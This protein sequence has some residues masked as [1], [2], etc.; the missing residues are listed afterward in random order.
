MRITPPVTTPEACEPSAAEVAAIRRNRLQR[1]RDE[2]ARADIAACVLFDP[3]HIRYATGSRNMQIYSSRNPARYLFV[4]AGG[5][6]V[7]FE[8]SGCDHL[9]AHLDTIDEVRPATAISYYFCGDRLAE[10]TGR[11]ADEIDALC[12]A[13]CGA[14]RRIALES[15]TAEAAFELRRRGWTVLDAQGPVERARA[16]KVPDEVKM[17]RSS[18][19]AVE[20]GVAELERSIAPGLSENA[21]WAR[22]HRAVIESDGDYV[23]TRLLC[24]GPRTNPW[25]QE[26]SPRPVGAGELVALD[27]D[28]VGRYGY[29]ADFSRTFLCGD[30]APSATQRRLYQLAY[31]Q[32][33]TNCERLEPGMSFRAFAAAAWPI[34]RA[35]RARRYFALAHGVGMNGEYPY[36]VHREDLDDKGYDGIIEPGMTLCMESYIGHEDGGEGVKLEEQLMVHDDHLELLSHYPFDPRLLAGA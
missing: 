31:Q 8:F 32:I 17:I 35:Y 20:R 7:L 22:L 13:H 30:K 33:R 5:A 25:F 4:P 16:I 11:W 12:R 6:V 9:A 26:S 24:S 36:I 15:A 27:T 14:N 29:Y 10:V 1:V 3:T 23:E 18:L 2:L 19:R 21:L 34:P 28:V